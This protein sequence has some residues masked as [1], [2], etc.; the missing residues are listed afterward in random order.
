ML[1]Q[2]ILAAVHLF[3][4]A[5]AF[6]AVLTRGTAFSQL[7]AGTGEL[8]RVLLA[9]NLWGLSALTLLITG[10]MRAFG[11]Y[12]KGSDYYLHQPLFHLKMTLLV[13]ILLVELAPMITLI[14]WRIASS[15]GVAPDAGRAKLY[16]RISHVE[17]LLLILMMVAATGMA[18]GVIFA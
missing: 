14:K 3:A 16:A 15:R 17:A 4:F 6:W 5:L 8:K 13:L 2:W 10:A 18:R 9:D 12:E 11:G 1:S 7:S